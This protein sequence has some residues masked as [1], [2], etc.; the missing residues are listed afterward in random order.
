MLPA[1]EP[2]VP[3]KEGLDDAV[4]VGVFLFH[5]GAD[6]VPVLSRGVGHLLLLGNALYALQKVPEADGV[7]KAH[8]LRCLIHLVCQV[9][10]H[11][12]VVAGEKL[13]GRVGPFPVFL[14]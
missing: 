8:L 3:Y 9:P 4:R 6:D 1:D 11:R 10:H 13:Q 12:S 7:L 2:P 14:S 5:G